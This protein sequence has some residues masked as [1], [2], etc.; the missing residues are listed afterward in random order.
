MRT[1]DK[2]E[3]NLL[4]MSATIRLVECVDM[5]KKPSNSVTGCNRGVERMGQS[6]T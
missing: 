5:T 3:L 6:S 1:L 4:A 2:I